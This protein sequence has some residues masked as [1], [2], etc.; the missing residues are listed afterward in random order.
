MYTYICSAKKLA[1]ILESDI[2]TELPIFLLSIR[3]YKNIKY[4]RRI[5]QT[6][7]GGRNPVDQGK[8]IFSK[9]FT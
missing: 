5:Q 7:R 8:S 2:T 6:Y 3:Q 4:I 1:Y 9:D